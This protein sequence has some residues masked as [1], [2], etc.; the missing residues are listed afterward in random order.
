MEEIG[1]LNIQNAVAHHRAQLISGTGDVTQSWQLGSFRFSNN[2]D[3]EI[4]N[5]ELSNTG[6]SFQLTVEGSNLFMRGGGLRGHKYELA[7][8]HMHFGSDFSRGSEHT[9]NGRHYPAEVHFV[10]KDTNTGSLAVLGFFVQIGPYSS[11]DSWDYLIGLLDAI[12][13]EG[14]QIEIRDKIVMGEFL[15]I[16]DKDMMG[17]F[18]R[19]MGSLTTPPCSEDVEWTVFHLP[20]YITWTQYRTIVNCCDDSHGGQIENNYRLTQPLNGRIVLTTFK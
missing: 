3:R 9:I 18:Y 13:E 1:V 2:F 17:G 10:F 11:S 5:A 16:H 14:S 20:L 12:K 7:Q 4:R 8:F 19:Y 6:H 15:P